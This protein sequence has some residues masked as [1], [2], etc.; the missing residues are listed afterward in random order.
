[1]KPTMKSTYALT[2]MQ[3]TTNGVMSAVLAVVALLTPAI[4][5]WGQSSFVPTTVVRLKAI[6]ARV[7]LDG[8]VEAVRQT[9]VSAQASGALVSVLVKA[10]DK[11]KAGQLLAVI[12]GREAAAS[13][14]R[15]QA[16]VSQA[17][18]ELHNAKVNW[19]RSQDLQSKGFVSKAAMDSAN[20]QYGS[21]SAVRD[22]AVAAYR[23]TVIFQGFTRVLAPFDGWVLQAHAQAGD[24]ALPGKP[25]LTV[26]A[27]QPLRAAVQVP[28]SLGQAA[29]LATHTTL[30]AD[31]SQNKVLVIT[32]LNHTIV[33]AAD[34][35][36]QTTE[37]RFELPLKEAANLL[38][39]Q[40]LHVQFLQAQAGGAE[41][42]VVPVGAVV[43]RGELTAVYVV[44]GQA[45]SLRAI[46]LGGH[47]T[48]DTIE[49]VAGLSAGEVIALD[50][51]RAGFANAQPAKPLE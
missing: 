1:M 4:Q 25:L 35:V 32:P 40:H 26:Y 19:E 41:K 38:P 47:S 12:D 45:F 46:R 18:A 17:E 33:P 49:V 8:V 37:W 48:N 23:Q 20:A 6:G 43:R 30:T 21:A 13:T 51:I 15:M 50:P 7:E 2:G 42:V 28:A 27:P 3:I 29:R 16:Q 22:Q 36:S 5:A 39:G 34:P 9:V 24:L 14:Q 10:G 44:I 31:T 11:V